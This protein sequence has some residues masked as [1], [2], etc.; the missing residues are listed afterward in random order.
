M[1]I[2]LFLELGIQK[3]SYIADKS[4]NRN[5]GIFK[6]VFIYM[7]TN[8]NVVNQNCEGKVEKGRQ[9]RESDSKQIKIPHIEESQ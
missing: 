7:R 4:N 3:L 8:K 9:V 2:S 1:L 6:D 5:R